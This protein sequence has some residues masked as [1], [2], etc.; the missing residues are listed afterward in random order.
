[1]EVAL[2]ELTRRLPH[3]RPDPTREVTYLAT[4]NT[5]AAK[6]LH[7]V[8]NPAQNPVLEDRP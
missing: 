6:V 5:R 3:M 1:M 7:V 4:S 2:E 8:W